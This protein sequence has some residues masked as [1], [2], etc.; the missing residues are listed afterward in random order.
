ME[1]ELIPHPMKRAP[2][3]H[4]A[5]SRLGQQGKLQV[6]LQRLPK[7]PTKMLAPGPPRCAGEQW[8]LPCGRARPRTTQIVTLPR[9]WRT[10]RAPQLWTPPRRTRRTIP[11]TQFLR[12]PGRRT[13]HLP[14]F[15]KGL[16]GLFWTALQEL[17]KKPK[18]LLLPEDFHLWV[19]R[20]AVGGC[21]LLGLPVPHLGRFLHLQTPPLR[22]TLRFRPH[23]YLKSIVVEVRDCFVQQFYQLN[24]PLKERLPIPARVHFQ[25]SSLCPALEHVGARKATSS[26]LIQETLPELVITTTTHLRQHYFR[27]LVL[28]L[29]KLESSNPQP[30]FCGSRVPALETGR[31][32]CLQGFTLFPKR[33]SIILQERAM[34]T[35]Q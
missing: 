4:R 6:S 5:F 16:V 19:N 33:R 22:L 30:N 28:T 15:R 17:S 12:A 24:P 18:E 20:P 10:S 32:D 34:G 27:A 13:H 9:A 23:F 21:S 8:K 26:Q 35:R 7:M 14:S 11:Q 29:T 31:M 25:Q 2:R 1:A 3:C